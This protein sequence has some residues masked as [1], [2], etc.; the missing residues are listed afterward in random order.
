MERTEVRRREGLAREALEVILR[1]V[2][3]A[4]LLQPLHRAWEIPV[5]PGV[6][7][8]QE[9]ALRYNYRAHTV[10]PSHFQAR[11]LGRDVGYGCVL[12][13]VLAYVELGQAG[14]QRLQR[15]VGVDAARDRVGPLDPH[16]C[17]APC[18]TASPT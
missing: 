13:Q 7:K 18:N 5:F 11:C 2:D 10:N 4:A 9:F 6:K 12:E 3:L 14:L 15:G 17:H 1:E 8:S 16:D